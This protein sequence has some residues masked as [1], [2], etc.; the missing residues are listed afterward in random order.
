VR[1]RAEFNNP[2]AKAKAMA[3]YGMAEKVAEINVQACFIEKESAK[4]VFMVTSAHEIAQ[5]AAR[6]AE[7]AREIEKCNDTLT[8]KPHAKSGKAKIKTK[9]MQQATFAEETQ[10]QSD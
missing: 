2:Y 4:Y 5:A 10:G 8:R 6:L 3:A 9:L 1:D 7:E